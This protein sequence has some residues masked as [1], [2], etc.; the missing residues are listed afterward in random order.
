VNRRDS[1]VNEDVKLQVAVNVDTNS[2]TFTDILEIENNST[3]S[4]DV[5]IGYDRDTQTNSL[6][7]SN[8]NSNPNLNQYGADVNVGGTSGVTAGIVQKIYQFTVPDPNSNGVNIISPTLSST[9]DEPGEVQSIPAGSQIQVSLQV[10]L[11]NILSIDVQD[12]IKDQ[13]Q[14]NP[15]NP[16]QQKRDTVDLLDA[17]TVGVQDPNNPF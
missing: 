14:F 1:N 6:N 4:V 17:I 10:D 9:K 11:S 8:A 13:T 3:N 7:D 5:G 12:R 16:F 2:V 15:S